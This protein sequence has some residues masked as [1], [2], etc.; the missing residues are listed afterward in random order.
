MPEGDL[1]MSK[2]KN[3][4]EVVSTVCKGMPLNIP[5]KKALETFLKDK[6]ASLKLVEAKANYADDTFD[7]EID[8]NL[9]VQKDLNFSRDLKIIHLEDLRAETGNPISR[10]DR[11]TGAETTIVVAGTK[12]ALK[13]LPSFPDSKGRRVARFTVSTGALVLPK[14]KNTITGRIAQE[15][16]ECGAVVLVKNAQGIADFRH[17]KASKDGSFVYLNKRYHPNGKITEEKNIRIV[18][19]DLHPAQLDPMVKQ[20]HKEICSLTKPIE[21][22]LHDADDFHSNSHHLE[23]R[24]NTKARLAENGELDLE[25]ENVVNVGEFKDYQDMVKTLLVDKSNHDEHRDRWIEDGRY[26]YEPNSYVAGHLGSLVKVFGGDAFQAS[27][28]AEAG[29]RAFFKE[30]GEKLK[31]HDYSPITFNFDKSLNRTKFLTRTDL[32]EVGGMILSKHGDKGANGAKGTTATFTQVGKKGV[33]GHGHFEEICRGVIRVATSSKT[34]LDY[35][36]GEAS[37]W[38]QSVVL[39]YEDGIGQIVRIKDGVWLS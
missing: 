35:N 5:F 32:I 38:T 39:V 7:D 25:K 23:G 19:G 36:K 18:F 20:A 9:L 11:L 34:Q 3:K 31:N 29:L 16:H 24:N 1:D 14:Y 6:G 26:I 27:L 4:Y 21:G 37:N 22:Y 8:M 12:Q 15:E 2:S 17:I 28:V 10:I 33:Y 13:S 30:L